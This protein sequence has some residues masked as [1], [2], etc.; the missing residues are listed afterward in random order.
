[1]PAA[2]MDAPNVSLTANLSADGRSLILTVFNLCT[3]PVGTLRLDMAPAFAGV[4]VEMLE[5]AEWRAVD[6]SWTGTTLCVHAGFDL[7]KARIL[8]L[9]KD[10][11]SAD[12]RTGNG[13]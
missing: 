10:A 2:V 9:R 13:V 11:W 4:S 6:H 8:R 5:E 12:S 3:D 1:M 7:L